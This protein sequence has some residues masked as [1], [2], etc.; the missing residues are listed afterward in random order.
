MGESNVL[1]VHGTE[2]PAVLPSRLEGIL[3]QGRVC[4]V[5]ARTVVAVVGECRGRRVCLRLLEEDVRLCEDGPCLFE[6]E[7]ALA[8]A[9]PVLAQLAE[10][11]LGRL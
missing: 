4:L 7:C 1:E 3:E 9:V 10:A 2:I 5:K 11:L 6:L 8:D